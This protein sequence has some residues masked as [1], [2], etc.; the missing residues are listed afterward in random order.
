MIL[1]SQV[2]FVWLILG[3]DFFVLVEFKDIFCKVGREVFLRDFRKRLTAKL[4]G[5]PLKIEFLRKKG[6]YFSIETACTW[7][8]VLSLRVKLQLFC[9]WLDGDSLSPLIFIFLIYIIVGK[10]LFISCLDIFCLWVK[11]WTS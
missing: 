3:S 1:R 8:H 11:G 5:F 9:G 4:K 10:Q 6:V 2:V 7:S